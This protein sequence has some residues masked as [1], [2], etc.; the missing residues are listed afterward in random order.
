LG[1]VPIL[2][3]III[4][5]ETASECLPYVNTVPNR[6]QISAFLISKDWLLKYV[7]LKLDSADFQNPPSDID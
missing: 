2:H 4:Y 3:D 5:E 1:D 7:G 6:V